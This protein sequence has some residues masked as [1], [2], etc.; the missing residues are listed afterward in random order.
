MT[1]DIPKEF[2]LRMQHQLGDEAV[3]FFA[4]LESPSPVSIRLSHF[5]G[6][7]KFALIDPVKWCDTGYYLDER[8]LFH[9]DPHW[10]GG[11][12]YVQEASS[13]ILDVVIK[14][15]P[16]TGDGIWIDLCAAPGGKTGI[17]AKHLGPGDV[18]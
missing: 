17:I 18:L 12:Y 16:R 4:A 2:K 14:Q 6:K 5:K 13:M 10:H 8:P 7:A 1:S 15:L 11:A 3:D 9:L